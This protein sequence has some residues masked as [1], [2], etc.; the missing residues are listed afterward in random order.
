M[1]SIKFVDQISASLAE[2]MQKDLVEYESSHAIDVNYK[3]FSLVLSDN[4][5][6]PIGVLNAYTAFAEIYIDDIWVD[7]SYRGKGYGRQLMEALV[8]HFKGKGFNNLNLVTSDFQAP[9]FYKK[10]GFELEFIRKNMKNPKLTKFFFVR[11]FDDET[12]TQGIIQ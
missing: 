7:S 1:A 4:D 10:C 5:N 2:K 11:Y 9:E 8:N 12:Q 6:E 3:Q